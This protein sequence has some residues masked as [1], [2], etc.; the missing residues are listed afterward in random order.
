MKYWVANH[1]IDLQ[2][3]TQNFSLGVRNILCLNLL[4]STNLCFSITLSKT[5]QQKVNL[6]EEVLNI[7]YQDYSNNGGDTITEEQML[8]GSFNN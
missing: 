4:T 3:F 8:G 6:V 7:T 1:Q 2:S 5:N